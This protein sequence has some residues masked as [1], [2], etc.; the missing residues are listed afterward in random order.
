MLH[1]IKTGYIQTDQGGVNTQYKS[2]T[3]Q[4]MGT[5]ALNIYGWLI[6]KLTVPQRTIESKTK[7]Q[8][9]IKIIC[10]LQCLYTGRKI[11]KG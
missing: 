7:M 1:K 4:K 2:N 3:N 9:I 5:Y 8:Y 6:C 11:L 10:I